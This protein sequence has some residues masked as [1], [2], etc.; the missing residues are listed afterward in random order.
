MSSL[1]YKYLRETTLLNELRDTMIPHL[2]AAQ[3]YI[4]DYYYCDEKNECNV[5]LGSI[6]DELNNV[7]TQLNQL[8]YTYEPGGTEDVSEET[9]KTILIRFIDTISDFISN[10]S[11][12]KFEAFNSNCRYIMNLI[13]VHRV[14]YIDEGEIL[15]ESVKYN[16]IKEAIEVHDD[17]NPKIWK[18]NME[19]KEDVSDKLH[20]IAD[21]FLNYIEIPLNIADIEIVGSNASYNYN[22]DSDIDLHIIVNNET[23]YIEPEILQQLYNSKKNAF[24]EK[25]DLDINGIPVELYIEDIKS[26]NATNGRYSLLK[27]EWVKIP[28]PI[29]Y[30]IPDIS[31]ELDDYK[32]KCNKALNSNDADKIN[33]LINEIYMMRKLGLADEGE[34]S[35]GNLTFKEL[36]SLGL[37]SKLRDKYYELRSKELSL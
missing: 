25:Y 36:R 37:I 32:D 31:K 10:F 18:S 15:T 27:N 19:I 22:A 8:D 35:I 29:R 9:F 4:N 3:N 6:L 24:N 11:E 28:Q 14:K 33:D 12:D 30:E 13:D 20:Q 16:I 17:L 26:G 2:H 7:V 34:A 23:N 5:L 21:E 1:L